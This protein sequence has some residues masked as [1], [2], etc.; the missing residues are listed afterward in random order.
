MKSNWKLNK[1][2]VDDIR[3]FKASGWS[4]K[5]ISY[6]FKVSQSH[7]SRI[8]TNKK[9]PDDSYDKCKTCKWNKNKKLIIEEEWD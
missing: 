7:I 6:M 1:D 9:W 4:N 8:L 5:E 3:S 2:L